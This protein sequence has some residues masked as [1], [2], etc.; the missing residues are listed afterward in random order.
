MRYGEETNDAHLEEAA[1]GPCRA[2]L[3][4]AGWGASMAEGRE[5]L[6]VHLPAQPWQMSLEKSM[7]S[8]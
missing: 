6:G 4:V 3:L 2:D 8:L 1:S 5:G 7:C